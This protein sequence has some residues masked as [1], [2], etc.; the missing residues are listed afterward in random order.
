MCD[1]K[2]NKVFQMVGPDFLVQNCVLNY[3]PNDIFF[4]HFS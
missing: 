1:L 3:F 4:R 2:K